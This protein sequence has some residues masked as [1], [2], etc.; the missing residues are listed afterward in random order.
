MTQAGT[1]QVDSAIEIQVVFD[2][3]GGRAF[4]MR[5]APLALDMT[6]EELDKHLDKVLAAVE[7][8]RAVYELLDEQWQ[9]EQ[10]MAR[11]TKYESN[12]VGVEE[13][14]RAWWE[15]EGRKGNWSLK[16]LTPNERNERERLTMALRN[17]RADAVSRREKIDKLR[18]RIA[19]GHVPEFSADHHTGVP[20]R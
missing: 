8:Q 7:R 20:G 15:A 1:V 14:S 17:D 2:R 18:K 9:L 19:N 5:F 11:I 6:K 3:E 10:Q 4:Q 12:M 16:E 13:T